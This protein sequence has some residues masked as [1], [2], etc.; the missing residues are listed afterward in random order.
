MSRRDVFSSADMTP[1]SIRGAQFAMRAQGYDPDQ[2]REYLDQVAS[3]VNVLLQDDVAA[4][5][6]AELKRNAEIAS[7]VVLAGQETA[8]RLR[9]QASDEARRIIE[10]TKRLAE[11]LRDASRAEVDRTRSHIDELRDSFINEMRDMYDRVGAT[12]YRF[13]NDR[14]ANIHL[15]S[16]SRTPEPSSTSP[17]LSSFG[18]AGAGTP[19]TSEQHGMLA[20]IDEG[21]PPVNPANEDNEIG[22]LELPEP[23]SDFGGDFVDDYSEYDEADEFS[24]AA[25]EPD[26]APAPGEPLV[27]LRPLQDEIHGELVVQTEDAALDDDEQAEALIAGVDEILGSDLPEPTPAPAVAPNAVSPEVMKGVV[28]KAMDEGQPRAMVERYLTETW[29]VTDASAFVDQTLADRNAG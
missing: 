27:D 3:A 26:I 25:P 23:D 22:R 29:G 7:R 14:A 2:V 21:E 11:E 17:A 28:L 8:E 13:E 12:L 6:R 1:E 24:D 18:R 19:P 20:E 4:A 5:M 9:E 16:E 15:T 10:D